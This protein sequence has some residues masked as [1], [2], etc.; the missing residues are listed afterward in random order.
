MLVLE[1]DQVKCQDPTLAVN[2]P[3][4]RLKHDHVSMKNDH[5]LVAGWLL[6]IWGLSAS[7]GSFTLPVHATADLPVDLLCSI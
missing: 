1:R 2:C 3:I 7:F 5:A 4:A 6:S